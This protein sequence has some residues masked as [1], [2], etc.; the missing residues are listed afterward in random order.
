M[1]FLGLPC[2]HAECRVD[3]KNSADEDVRRPQR[4]LA[5]KVAGS[6][7]GTRAVQPIR[8]RQ[9]RDFACSGMMT[10]AKQLMLRR[11]APNESRRHSFPFPTLQ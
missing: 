7:V 6:A 2:L 9:L 11:S 10:K 3:L 1:L 4:E 5:G 8:A